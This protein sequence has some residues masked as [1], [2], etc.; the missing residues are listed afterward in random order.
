MTPVCLWRSERRR[1]GRSTSTQRP[2][3]LTLL[4]GTKFWL[5][6]TQTEL[7]RELCRDSERLEDLLKLL[8]EGWKRLTHVEWAIQ[9]HGESGVLPWG[10][11]HA[12]LTLPDKINSP[13]QLCSG[14]LSTA[15]TGSACSG[16]RG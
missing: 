15:A 3:Q 14:T 10:L 5:V 16:R 4:S 7:A 1:F 6:C 8:E 2:H 13:T 12:E 9:G 11:A